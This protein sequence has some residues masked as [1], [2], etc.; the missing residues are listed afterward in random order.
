M[1]QIFFSNDVRLA[2]RPNVLQSRVEIF[3]ACPDL[4]EKKSVDEYNKMTT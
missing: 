1:D 4:V 2:S 3:S